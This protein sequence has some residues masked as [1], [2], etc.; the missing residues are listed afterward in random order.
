MRRFVHALLLAAVALF[1]LGAT[2]DRA[3]VRDATVYQTELD[4]MEQVGVQQADLLSGFLLTYC[5]CEDGEFTTADCRKAA[6]TVVTV[7]ARVPW[8]KAMALYNAGILEERPPE[9]P[10]EVA[11]TSTLCPTTPMGSVR[12]VPE[13]YGAGWPTPD[14]EVEEAEEAGAPTGDHD[15]MEEGGS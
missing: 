13:N 5:T 9:T 11:D 8:H 6:E 3:V 7:Q 12:M 4:F 15:A 14:P 1:M 10:P 2:C